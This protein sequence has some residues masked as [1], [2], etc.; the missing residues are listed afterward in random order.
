MIEVTYAAFRKALDLMVINTTCACNACRNLP[1]L[2]LKFIVHYG[3]FSIQELGNY[4]ELVGVEVNLIHRLLKNEISQKTGLKA[5]AAYTEAVAEVLDLREVVGGMTPHLESYENIGAVR[6]YVQDLHDVWKRKKN[7]LR[8]EVKPED[9]LA[10]LEYEFAI[11]QSLLWDYV[12]RPEYRALLLG[13]DNQTVENRIGG[14]TGPD[15][16]YYCAHGSNVSVHTILDWQPFEQYTTH[17]THP[18]PNVGAKYTYRLIPDGDRTRLIQLWGK[19]SGPWPLRAISDL[20]A[21]FL[22]IPQASKGAQVLRDQIDRDLQAGR[23]SAL[24]SIK[25]Q[26][27]DV[28]AAINAS[29]SDTGQRRTGMEPSP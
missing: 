4:R 10:T 26:D 25:I 29:L 3:M 8:V 22:I 20:V 9:A 28:D 13:A 7:E 2:D 24:P 1:Q 16:I 11:P 14:R 6:L 5:Y 19:A 18:I 23:T 17:E 12:T 21:R 27:L 15:T